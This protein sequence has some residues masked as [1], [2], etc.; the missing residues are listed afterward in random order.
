MLGICLQTAS[1]S[2]LVWA[3]PGAPGL[4]RPLT[5]VAS[6]AELGLWVS[7]LTLN[8]SKTPLVCSFPIGEPE[9][10]AP[11]QSAASHYSVLVTGYYEVLIHRTRT[12]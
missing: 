3:G 10:G 9:L 8:P 4:K 6:L 1:A 11:A 7:V 2:S 5:D 12:L